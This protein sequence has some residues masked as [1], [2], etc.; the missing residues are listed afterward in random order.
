MID[1]R[2]KSVLLVQRLSGEH[3][4]C[5]IHLVR[6][7]QCPS[8]MMSFEQLQEMEKHRSVLSANRILPTWV[9]NSNANWTLG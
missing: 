7:F 8:I 5:C 6:I 3:M 4:A 2:N 9:E 1:G